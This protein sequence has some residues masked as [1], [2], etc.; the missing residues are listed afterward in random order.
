MM[1]SFIQ[2]QPEH[3]GILRIILDSTKGEAWKGLED[4]REVQ[5]LLRTCIVGL[6][7][8]WSQTR[9]LQWRYAYTVIHKNV[10]H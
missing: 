4:V 8:L 7:V 2:F 1:V 3:T 6:G 5:R 9:K 10:D